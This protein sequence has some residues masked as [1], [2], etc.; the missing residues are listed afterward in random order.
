MAE[1]ELGADAWNWR[2][3]DGRVLGFEIAALDRKLAE[4]R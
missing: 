3:T 1:G 2:Q 4:T